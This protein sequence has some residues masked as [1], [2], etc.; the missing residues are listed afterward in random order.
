ML[1]LNSKLSAPPKD[2]HSDGGEAGLYSLSQLLNE[3]AFAKNQGFFR[4]NSTL[5]IV[6]L[7][8]END[9]CARYPAGVTPIHD[10]KEAKIFKRDCVNPNVTAHTVYQ[11]LST[12]QGNN[13]LLISGII[14]INQA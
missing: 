12:L 13:P 4:S 6:F 11:Q 8:D 7:A 1:P 2:P 10:K 5:V 14:Y 3:N 9:I